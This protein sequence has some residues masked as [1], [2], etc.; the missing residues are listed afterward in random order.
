MMHELQLDN[1]G[2]GAA[3]PFPGTSLFRQVV[4][5]KLLL[6][7]WNLKELWKT[8]VSLGQADFL[9]KPYNMSIDDLYKWKEKFDSM[10]D[11]FWKT[12]PNPSPFKK[13]ADSNN[14]KKN[15]LVFESTDKI[16]T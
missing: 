12:N 8:P 16:A 2:V 3:I 13:I 9:I 15:A 14:V 7:E 6:G 10:K 5:D 11:K 4:K 1:S